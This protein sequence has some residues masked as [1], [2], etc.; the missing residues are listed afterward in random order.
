MSEYTSVNIKILNKNYQLKCKYDEVERL[1]QAGAHLDMKM[2]QIQQ[3]GNA[4][5]FER[6]AMMAALDVC[7][8]LMTIR[9]EQ[10]D[11]DSQVNER[12]HALSDRISNLIDDNNIELH[13]TTVGEQQQMEL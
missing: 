12:L 7:Y 13:T 9:D 11:F 1:Q 10:N 3:A 6:T 8:E 4:V 2:Q 5:G